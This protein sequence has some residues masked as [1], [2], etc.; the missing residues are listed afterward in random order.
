MQSKS[1]LF[2]MELMITTLFFALA[3]TVCV[4]LFVKAHQINRETRVRDA[5][6]VSV[7]NIAETWLAGES[8]LADGDREVTVTDGLTLYY[9]GAWEAVDA[10]AAVYVLTLTQSGDHENDYAQLTVEKIGENTSVF[11]LD[12]TKHRQKEAEKHA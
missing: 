10:S 7:Q 8:S 6:L 9:D 5:M 2:L 12:L 1:A 3:S 4:Q 11:S